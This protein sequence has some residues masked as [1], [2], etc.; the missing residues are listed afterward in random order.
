MQTRICKE[1]RHRQQHPEQHM[2]LHASTMCLPSAAA[3]ADVLPSPSR[4]AFLVTTTAIFAP[5]VSWYFGLPASNQPAIIRV[6]VVGEDCRMWKK[7]CYAAGPSA[8]VFSKLPK[9]SQTE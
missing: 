8:S 2:C 4:D 5:A 9:A 7:M 6:I 1:V 3:S